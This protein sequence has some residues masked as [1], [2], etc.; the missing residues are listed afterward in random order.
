MAEP[1]EIRQQSIEQRLVEFDL[2]ISD[3]HDR[4]IYA[5]IQAADAV[6]PLAPKGA[7]GRHAHDYCV[8]ALRSV[9]LAKSGWEIV[10]D[11]FVARTVHRKKRIAIVVASGNE[12]T[13]IPGT[14]SDFTTKWHKGSRAFAGAPTNQQMGF[15]DVDGSGFDWGL[16][17]NDPS[18][19]WRL[20]YLLHYRTKD[21]VRL[22]LSAPGHL[23]DAE[24]PRSWI[25]RILLPPYIVSQSDGGSGS[26]SRDDDDRDDGSARVEVPVQKR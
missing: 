22:E 2:T 15:D 13:G 10:E 26:A 14:D 17:E 16:R 19:E 1:L 11:D 24:F 4:I 18:M 7:P 23:D 9:L 5:A 12:L 8:A 20:W 25:E 21:S 6:S 3:I